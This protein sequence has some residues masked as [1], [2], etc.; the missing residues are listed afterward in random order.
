MSTAPSQDLTFYEGEADVV[1]ATVVDEAGSAFDLTGGTLKYQVVDDTETA[2]VTKTT[3]DGS[4]T[5]TNA[6]GGVLNIDIDASDTQ[7]AVGS[8]RHELRIERG[9]Y[10]E[11][12]LVG[13]FIILD[14]VYHT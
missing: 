12:L 5:I 7:Q 1:I 2:L 8:Y 11:T 6:A 14:S 9:E 4:I 13:N 3:A 10:I